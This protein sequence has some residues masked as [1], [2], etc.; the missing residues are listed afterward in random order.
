MGASFYE[1]NGQRVRCGEGKN[2]LSL[3]FRPTEVPSEEQAGALVF[4]GSAATV[5][6]SGDTVSVVNMHTGRV[7]VVVNNEHVIHRRESRTTR[8]TLDRAGEVFRM[9][10]DTDH[11]V[12]VHPDDATAPILL[13]SSHRR[14]KR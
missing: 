14:R 8:H 10:V 3:I 7:H 9:V 5:T 12:S 13:L 1:R 4:R 6:E 11:S 2:F